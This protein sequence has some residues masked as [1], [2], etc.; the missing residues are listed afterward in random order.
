M[1]YRRWLINQ[2][3]LNIRKSARD[4]VFRRVERVIKNSLTKKSKLSDFPEVDKYLRLKF[5]DVDLSSIKFYIAPPK[6]LERSGWKNIGGCYI[7]DK[8]TIIVKSKIDSYYK[9]KGKFQ[10]LMR[11]ACPMKTDV[12]DVIVHEFIHAV[13][14]IIERSSS[15]YRHMEEE[16]VY[17]NCIDFYYAKDMTDDDIV[18][19]NFL[20]F[21]LH[22]I[23]ESTKEM[24]SA[25]AKAGRTISDIRGMTEEEY[26]RFLN[27]KADIIVPYIV[28]R[29]QKK[30]HN[31]IELYHKYGAKMYK[32]SANDAGKD[33]IATRFSSLDLD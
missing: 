7:R 29:A 23:H 8:K 12:E 33:K 24:S 5:P 32:I 3:I 27:L 15:R 4:Q 11:G 18:N 25:F 20:P 6:V 30:S 16:F 10:R 14:D 22:D 9:A 2:E 26:R 17:T 21:C 13:S 19:N 28:E 1:S 31:M